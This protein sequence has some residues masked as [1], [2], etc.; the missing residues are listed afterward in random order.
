MS[1][2]LD[3]SRFGIFGIFGIFASASFLV[4]SEG[5]LNS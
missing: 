2:I 1:K 4:E 3:I 5:E